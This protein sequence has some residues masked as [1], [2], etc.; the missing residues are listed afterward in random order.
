MGP[1]GDKAPSRG[2]E[3]RPELAARIRGLLEDCAD[4]ALLAGILDLVLAEFASPSGWLGLVDEGGSLI[5][6]ARM[7]IPEQDEDLGAYSKPNNDS[8]LGK[9]GPDGRSMD[10]DIVFR[11]QVIGSIQ[12]ANRQTAYTNREAEDLQ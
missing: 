2:L 4:E 12:V 10:S 3:A 1:T 6:A 7:G 5:S 8:G 11:R 9:Q